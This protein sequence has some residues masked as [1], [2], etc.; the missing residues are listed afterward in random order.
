[1]FSQLVTLL[2]QVELKVPRPIAYPL[3]WTLNV[4]HKHNQVYVYFILGICLF[5]YIL[6]LNLLRISE[7]DANSIILTVKN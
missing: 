3:I 2:F 1:M 4:A 6:I 7:T 5:I